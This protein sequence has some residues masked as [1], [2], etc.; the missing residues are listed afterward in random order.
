MDALAI[1][2]DEVRELIRRRGLDPLHQAGEVRRLVEAAVTDYDERA[3]MGP[4]PPIGPLDAARKFLFDAV[5]GFGVLQPLLDDPTIEEVWINAPRLSDERGRD[6]GARDVVVAEEAEAIR[7]LYRQ[8]L[9]GE[10]LRNMA[11]Y[12]NDRGFVTGRGNPF[13]GNVV[14]NMLRK[15]R[16]AGHRTHGKEIVSKGD[17]EPLISQETYD[18]ALAVLG[19]PGRRHSRGLEAKYLLSGVG[20]CGRCAGTLRPSVGSR[21]PAS[22]ICP[23]CM[24]LTRQIAPVDE[25]VEAMMVARLAVPGLQARMSG[26]PTAAAA[27][28]ENRDTILARLDDAADKFADGSIDARMLARINARLQPQLKAAEADVLRSQPTG[29]LDGM[30]GAA[31]ATAWAAATIHRRKEIIKTLA[32]VTVLP[33]GPGIRFSP[34]QIRFDWIEAS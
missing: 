13:Q 3:L 26:D 25:V 14:G 9:G 33:S 29:I 18:Q 27:A 23:T 15:P 17:W 20:L 10:S 8:L 19:T 7:E 31:A 34:E 11:K 21:R 5:A 32:K 30:T 16:Y 24:R 6:T 1:V 22:Y 2:E 12:L 4:L 28:A